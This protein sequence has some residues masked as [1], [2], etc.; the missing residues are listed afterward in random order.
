MFD[1][2]SNNISE[3]I[4]KEPGELSHAH[5]IAIGLLAAAIGGLCSYGY[6]TLRKVPGLLAQ[7]PG[8][9]KSWERVN[10]HLAEMEGV[11][12][13]WGR[14]Q[15]ELQ[16]HVAKLDKQTAAR[17]QA[18]RKQVQGLKV[19]IQSRVHDEVA[20]ET[21][22]ME[23][24]LSQ[25]QAKSAEGHA[26]LE[27]EVSTLREETARQA[28]GGRAEVAHAVVQIETRRS[29]GPLVRKVDVDGAVS[30]HVARARVV[31]EGERSWQPCLGLVDELTGLRAHEQVALAPRKRRCVRTVVGDEQI[32]QTVTVEVR[33][34]QVAGAG[35]R[36]DTAGE[37]RG[38]CV[39]ER[40]AAIV[41]ERLQRREP[42]RGGAAPRD[43]DVGATVV[44]EV[45]Q[46]L[47]ELVVEPVLARDRRRDAEAP[48]FEVQPRRRHRSGRWRDGR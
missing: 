2:R 5:W 45:Q 39:N 31:G 14:S 30:V 32:G 1:T 36:R 20:A 46:S 12:K 25:A 47:E 27:A 29:R 18:S 28:D 26:K 33:D 16:E 8:F 38:R 9:Q 22:E 34:H 40:P 4:N 35:Q 13:D 19:E 21:Q 43:H 42:L 48:G 11:I 3:K 15:Q 6:P 44:I 10:T 37:H 41:M 24:Q 23:T 7:L 17:F